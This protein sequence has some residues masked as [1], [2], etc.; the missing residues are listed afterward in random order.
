VVR[1]R[2]FIAVLA[3]ATG[4]AIAASDWSGLQAVVELMAR[5]LPLLLIGVGVAAVIRAVVPAGLRIG[6][7]LLIMAGAVWIALNTDGGTTW[8][9]DAA[10]P[11]LIWGGVV[12]ALMLG[13]P[14][15]EDSL[16]TFT[17]TVTAIL[18]PREPVHGTEAPA[19]LTVRAL[20]TRLTLD[21]TDTRPPKSGRIDL[22]LSV[23]AGV[24]EL[25]L[26]SDWE[27]LVG[28]IAAARGVRFRGRVSKRRFANDGD[29]PEG[30]RWVVIHVLGLGG[31][32]NLKRGR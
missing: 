30:A 28:R 6:P 29:P 9:Q 22:H 19:H 12:L 21:L 16:R 8:L 20:L 4:G 2:A 26:P 5:T 32:V 31:T 25:I 7:L 17:R 27:V 24:I 23:F 3:A 13:G 10:A 1:V 14:M 11:L 18:W 15:E